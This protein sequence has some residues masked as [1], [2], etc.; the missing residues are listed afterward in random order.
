MKQRALISAVLSIAMAAPAAQAA[1]PRRKPVQVPVEARSKAILTVDGLKFRDLDG[2]GKLTPYED[3]RLSPAR[4]A[5][6]LLGRMTLAEKAG[7]MM[8]GT[9]PGRGG[10]LGRSAEGYDMTALAPLIKDLSITSFIT[11]LSLAPAAMAEQSNAV[12]ALAEA[13]RLGIPVTISTDPRNH[14]HHV[15]GAGESAAGVTQWPELL[16]FAALGDARRVRQFATIAR[17]E[18]RAV[19]IHEAL[20]P[21][22]DLA[23]EPRWSRITG[24]FGSDPR[25]SSRLGGAY[26]QG[27][28][29]GARGLGRDGV[30]TVAKHWVGYGALPDGFDSHSYYGRVAK[31]T[32]AELDMHVEAFK[33]A[34]AAGTAG[35]MPTYPILSGPTVGGKPIEPYGAGF[36]HVLL[37]D[38]LREKLGFKGIILSDWAITKDC[39]ERC[40]AP[41]AEAPQR[42]QDISMAWGV[43]NLTVEQRYALG[44][45]AGIDQFGGTQD[46]GPLLNA[47]KNGS[48]SEARIDQSV[49]RI[50]TAKFRQGLFDDPY[51]DPAKAEAII[52]DKASHDLAE[53]TQRE[54]Q[55]LL[56]N[57]KG[58][59]PFKAGK[60]WLSGVE[61]KAAQAAGLTV[62]TTPEEADFA[63]VR[64]ESPSEML[65]PNHFFGSRQKEGRLDFR[66][67]D[68]AFEAVKQ[69]K[70]AGKPV[71]LA[72]FLDRPAI[73]TN[74]LDKT[75]VILGNF[76]ASDA[77][78]FD[79]LLGRANAKGR[80]PFELPS[81]MEAVEAQDPAM[82][83]DSRKPLFKRGD[84]IV[85]R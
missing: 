83:D 6:D 31:L 27:F 75:D 41:T 72:I 42:P 20:S 50:L 71:V 48:V 37:T 16:G 70:A 10:E 79:V 57:R 52:A 24:T 13:T 56:T 7:Q 17:R 1:E 49:L 54:A 59:L 45:Q 47:V 3:W 53:R 14:F 4:R 69:A 63:L 33:G 32:T 44:I 66:D 43:E 77:A 61:A 64:A 11:R 9:L 85:Q 76:G 5:R 65:H 81:S 19:G 84:G 35:I 40:K 82:P 39:N 58:L 67:G 22:V 2:N 28:Q 60:V 74:M 21:Q 38:L 29:G 73:L 78:V 51:T 15:L 34:L 36:S 26:V 55:V 46:V 80:L 18:Y 8:H 23:S 25:L 62:V 12:Q 30:M 68:A